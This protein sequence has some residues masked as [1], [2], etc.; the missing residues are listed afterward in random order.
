MVRR[1][2]IGCEVSGV[3][4][5]EEAAPANCELA[6]LFRQQYMQVG[7]AHWHSRN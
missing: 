5:K 6:C 2:S 3:Q 4:G 1:T 7:D